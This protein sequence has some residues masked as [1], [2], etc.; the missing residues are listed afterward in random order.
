MVFRAGQRIG[1]ATRL[2][3]DTVKIATPHMDTSSCDEGTTTKGMLE[4]LEH[5]EGDWR[6]GLNWKQVLEATREPQR[7]KAYKEWHKEWEQKIKIGE[8]EGQEGAVTEAIKDCYR[9]LIF[10]YKEVVS[11]NPKKPGIIPS[12]FHQII[13]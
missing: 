11:R 8:E 1:V 2:H 6:K 13:S 9:R 12:I 7:D 5:E 4:T 10:A 3:K